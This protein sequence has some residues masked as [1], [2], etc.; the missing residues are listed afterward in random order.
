MYTSAPDLITKKT[1]KHQL[2]CR[3]LCGLPVGRQS[4]KKILFSFVQPTKITDHK[5]QI[6]IVKLFNFFNGGL[7]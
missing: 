5:H 6:I 7:Y 1:A 2:V 3:L 4:A